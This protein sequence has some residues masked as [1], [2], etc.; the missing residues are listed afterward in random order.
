MA[1]GGGYLMCYV[2]I[3]TKNTK[4]FIKDYPKVGVQFGFHQCS[5]F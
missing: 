5:T 4:L 2:S 1:S 3:N